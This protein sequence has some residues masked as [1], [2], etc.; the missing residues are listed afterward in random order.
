MA[1]DVWKWDPNSFLD[2]FPVEDTP[3]IKLLLNSAGVLMA[4]RGE[5]IDKVLNSDLHSLGE[6]IDTLFPETAG[7]RGLR[8]AHARAMEGWPTA[9]YRPKPSAPFVNLSFNSI[10]SL[11]LTRVP[12]LAARSRRVFPAG[13]LLCTPRS[14]LITYRALWYRALWFTPKRHSQWPSTP[15]GSGKTTRESAAS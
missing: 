8:E 14:F 10:T 4:G 11:W 15:A 5:S 2:D 7:N 1:N 12:G 9:G 6:C 3:G 13:I